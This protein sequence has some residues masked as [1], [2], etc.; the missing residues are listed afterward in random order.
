MSTNLRSFI[1]LFLLMFKIIF[2]IWFQVQA[3]FQTVQKQTAFIAITFWG[4]GAFRLHTQ[5]IPVQLGV[6]KHLRFISFINNPNFN[7]SILNNGRETHITKLDFVLIKSRPW[8]TGVF[9]YKG[10]ISTFRG[11]D[12][13][14]CRKRGMYRT[15][16]W[17]VFLI[18][19]ALWHSGRDQKY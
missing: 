1:F 15:K 2:D 18:G 6:S 17:G 19:H 10:S 13:I 8:C 16:T 12:V 9:P 3:T 4:S 11:P 5:K 14:S 7:T